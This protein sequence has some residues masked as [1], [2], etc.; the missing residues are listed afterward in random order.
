MGNNR[1]GAGISLQGSRE[2]SRD[3]RGKLCQWI[4]AADRKR[5]EAPDSRLNNAT[6]NLNRQTGLT[7]SMTR[8]LIAR[9]R[10]IR[11]NSKIIRASRSP[12]DPFQDKAAAQASKTSRRANS[13]ARL[14]KT[15]RIR[16]RLPKSKP[17]NRFKNRS[18][19]KEW[20]PASPAPIRTSWSH[21]PSVSFLK[22]I[23]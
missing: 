7:N 22:C 5:R 2:L 4:Q 11:S 1:A 8:T 10:T 6:K 9:V 17:P 15:H 14:R 13:A 23:P 16:V 21:V 18:R 19:I 3:Q 20:E 12:P